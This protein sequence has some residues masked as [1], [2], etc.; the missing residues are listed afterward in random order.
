MLNGP[1]WEFLPLG[2]RLVRKK[3]VNRCTSRCKSPD[4]MGY[5]VFPNFPHRQTTH[6]PIS[7]F[8]PTIAPTRHPSKMINSLCNPPPRYIYVVSSGP[9]RLR[10][11]IFN[12]NKHLRMNLLFNAYCCY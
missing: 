3:E 11:T 4:V 8:T 2:K 5:N 9:L 1:L 10:F 6:V 7:A 12:H